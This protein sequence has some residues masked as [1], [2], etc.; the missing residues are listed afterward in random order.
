MN[1]LYESILNSSQRSS[2]IYTVETGQ[3][4]GYTKVCQRQEQKREKDAADLMAQLL[5]MYLQ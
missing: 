4:F 5:P 2:H 3:H 1:V